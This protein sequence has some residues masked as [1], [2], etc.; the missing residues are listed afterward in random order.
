MRPPRE[1]TKPWYRQFWP[2][3]LIS[4]PGAVVVASMVT[5]YLAVETK[6]GLVQDDY[7]KKGLGIHKDAAKTATARQLNIQAKL[8]YEPETGEIVVALNEAAIG[9]VQQLHLT[10]FHPTRD[11]RDQV[12]DLSRL[13]GRT[14]RGTLLALEPANWRMSIEPPGGQ[15][16]IS[17]RLAVP[18][19]RTAEL[20]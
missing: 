16:R 20:Q 2:W 9:Q 3:F 1:D 12:V 14:F 6:D 19:L 15:W 8:T 13:D 17:G 5:I 4:L 18:Q 7:Y 11:N 10:A